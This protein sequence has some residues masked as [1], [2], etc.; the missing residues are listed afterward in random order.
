MITIEGKYK[1]K[2]QREIIEKAYKTFKEHLKGDSEL[3]YANFSIGIENRTLT[4]DNEVDFYSN[5]RN[6]V[7]M[8][9]LSYSFKSS[10]QFSLYYR[11]SYKETT[12]KITLPTQ[13]EIE[14]VL[15]LFEEDYKA[16]LKE[17]TNC[18]ISCAI[19][20]PIHSCFIN[21]DLIH[22]LEGYL[23]RN[24]E[25][26]GSNEFKLM[27]SD[28]DSNEELDSIEYYKFNY[29]NNDINRIVISLG[30]HANYA[31]IHFSPEKNSSTIKVQFI[32]DDAKE[33]ANGLVIEILKI[34]ENYKN[35]NYLL[36]PPL[37]IDVIMSATL[38]VLTSLTI[39]YALI[40]IASGSSLSS[41]IQDKPLIYSLFI[42]STLVL[43]YIY[44]H[45]N[46]Y[47]VFNTR[48]NEGFRKW[49]SWLTLTIMEFSLG[50]IFALI[51]K[52]A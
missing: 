11:D 38:F 25:K 50:I 16:N 32:R 3:V 9:T 34:L 42:I 6:E 12:I 1:Y 18:K 29:F 21:K 37:M 30:D 41:L 33:I 7:K 27:I 31:E 23:K 35:S 28:P 2:F 19:S 49:F 39:M 22:D 14:K 24:S 4:L 5:Y 26:I 46:P 44:K 17:K 13:T 8:A 43:F 51:L 48:K 15:S 40:L 45:F 52:L 20:K 36:Y 47:Y 10:Y